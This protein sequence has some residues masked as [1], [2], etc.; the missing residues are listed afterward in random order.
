[1]EVFDS[2]D[3]WVVVHCYAYTEHIFLNLSP[4]LISNCLLSHI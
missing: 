1:M 3:Y 4:F 2:F